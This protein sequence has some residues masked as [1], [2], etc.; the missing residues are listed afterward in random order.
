MLYL[1]VM[2]PV[3]KTIITYSIIEAILLSATLYILDLSDLNIPEYIPYTPITIS[4]LLFSTILIGMCIGAEKQILRFQ[5]DLS[6]TKLALYGAAA[7]CLA[8]L[9][10]QELR[11]SLLP[12]DRLNNFYTGM[13]AVAAM[14]II[15]SWLT[16]FQLKTR[17]T[18]MLIIYIVI[19]CLLIR[20][21]QQFPSFI[22]QTN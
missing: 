7:G 21:A 12:S 20:V 13:L 15:I 17:R 4:G 2:N 8:E 3:F 11:Y 6:V 18:T 22:Q 9:T 1:V 14:V 16:A 10:Y 5:P 19:I